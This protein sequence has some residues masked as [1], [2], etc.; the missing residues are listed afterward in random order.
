M[1]VHLMRFAGVAAGLVS[2]TMRGLSTAP[3]A[4]ASCAAAIAYGTVTYF[5]LGQR[6]LDTADVGGPVGPAACPRATT[7]SGRESF[8]PGRRRSR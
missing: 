8:P 5:G 4:T 6:A 7:W 1:T 2:L 3:G